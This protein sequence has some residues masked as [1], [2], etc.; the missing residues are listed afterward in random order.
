[1]AETLKPCPFCGKSKG[2][3]VRR[4]EI[5]KEFKVIIYRVECSGCNAQGPKDYNAV[6]AVEYWNNRNA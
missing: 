2:L 1:M 5:S 4:K 3:A 6:K